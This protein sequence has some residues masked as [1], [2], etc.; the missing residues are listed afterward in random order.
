MVLTLGS[1]TAGSGT[2]GLLHHTQLVG[3]LLSL[4]RDSSD[5]VLRLIMR[6]HHGRSGCHF[7]RNGLCYPRLFVATSA[8]WDKLGG[9]V[10]LEDNN[11]PTVLFGRATYEFLFHGSNTG[12]NRVALRFVLAEDIASSPV[13]FPRWEGINFCRTIADGQIGGCRAR[14]LG[15]DSAGDQR[16]EK[17]VTE[18]SSN[19]PGE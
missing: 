1:S 17:T 13:A 10:V 14:W 9:V 18:S 4:A 19:E 2:L 11:Q 3:E 16:A 8:N 5:G 7:E 6:R 15:M 12:R